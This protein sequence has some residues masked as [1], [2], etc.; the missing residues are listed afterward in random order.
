MKTGREVFIRPIR[1][2]DEP[3]HHV[4]LSKLTPEDIRFRFFGMVKGL[5]HSQMA[6]L[7]QIDYDR[8]MAFIAIGQDDKHEDETLGVVRVV[9]TRDNSVAEFSIVVRSDLKSTGLGKELMKKMI[10]YSKSRQTKALV[11]QVLRDNSR[12]IHFVEALGFT[13]T[14]HPEPN[15]IEVTLDLQNPAP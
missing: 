4:F 5:P 1:P 7:T 15:V 11:G 8:D 14:G 9:S 13:R 10:A 2:E 12:M 3:N 6:R